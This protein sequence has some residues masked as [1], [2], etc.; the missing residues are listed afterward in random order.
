[1]VTQA[2]LNLKGALETFKKSNNSLVPI[3]E[4]IANSLEAITTK[5]YSPNE[6]PEITVTLDYSGVQDEVSNLQAVYI[7]DNGIG[8]TDENY[9]RFQEFINKSKGFNNRGT[10]RLQFLHRF[11]K[12]RIESSFFELSKLKKRSFDFDSVNF[13][14]PQALED[15]QIRESSCTKVSML[16]PVLTEKE[17][18]RFDELT[19][20]NLVDEIRQ[21]YLLRFFLD[22]QSLDVVPPEIWVIYLF[23][24]QQTAKLPVW[25]DA[26]PKP[27][28]QGE[29]D[30][31]YSKI[32]DIGSE[33]PSWVS[34]PNE[35]EKI[36]WAHFEMSGAEQKQNKIYLCSKNVAVSTINFSELKVNEEFNGSR[37]L[38]FF[39][40]DVFDRSENVSDSVDEFTFPT[41]SEEKSKLNDFFNDPDQTYLFMDD[42][43]EVIEKE[44][45]EIFE[46][47]ISAKK[48]KLADVTEIAKA[49]AIPENVVNAISVNASDNEATITTKL[50]SEQGKQHAKKA[51]QAKK[52]F[53]SLKELNPSNKDYQENLDKKVA[54]F[55][56]LVADQNKED[57]SRYVLRR[58]MIA[59]VLSKIL[60]E[61]LGVQTEDVL[62]SI[63]RKDPEG[64]IHDLIFRRKTKTSSVN[65][66]WILNEEFLHYEGTSELPIDQITN[67]AGKKLLRDVSKSE[68]EEFGIKLKRRPDIFLFLEE[69]K[70]I[71]IEL[72][73]PNV[74]VSDHLNQLSRYCSLIA[75]YSQTPIK[76][77]FCYLIGENFNAATDLGD[78][79]STVSGDY[80]RDNIKVR[81]VKDRDKVIA[82]HQIN[83]LKLSSLITRARRRNKSFA[84][85]LGVRKLLES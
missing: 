35:L 29:F 60:K 10:G 83:I 27:T 48:E 18:N 82:I 62:G 42:I 5:N 81:D 19:P 23:D 21:K 22:K 52:V 14:T 12:T 30:V 45:Y 13:I 67:G 84:D 24:G 47:V 72:K 57:L 70:C 37:Y 75:N 85:K 56:N 36:K 31:N 68:I 46:G 64:L 78:Y 11:E 71:L 4:A 59:G 53:E 9:E 32:D 43:N 34:V 80:V 40:G 8:F 73:A 6:T 63:V 16:R 74:D 33:Q 55:S 69:G 7:E 79:E 38:T 25:G 44:L 26:I 1:M 20:Q 17:R 51:Y 58:E 76:K 15:D 49:H 65:D 41:K 3:F 50:F 77:F 66:L 54:E 39:Y 28:N 2:K 61:E